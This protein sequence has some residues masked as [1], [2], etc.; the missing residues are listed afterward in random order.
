MFGAE[1]ANELR[2][3]GV[4]RGGLGD[5]L[6]ETV[7]SAVSLGTASATSLTPGIRSTSAATSSMSPSGSVEATIVPV[8]MRG[9]FEPGPKCSAVRSYACRASLEVGWLPAFGRASCR[10][11]AGIATMPRPTT[12]AIVVTT[13]CR[14]TAITQRCANPRRGRAP[15]LFRRGQ[16]TTPGPSRI[17]GERG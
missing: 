2:G 7:V 16:P 9:P 6:D 5:D 10:L 1:V 15:A 13:G 14:V 4:I 11:A 17:R 12:T 8:M 3:R